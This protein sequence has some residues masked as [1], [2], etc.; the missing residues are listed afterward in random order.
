M[1]MTAFDTATY[2][3]LQEARF[4]K[5]FPDGEP[6]WA[7]L[8]QIPAWLESAKELG[9]IEGEV[10]EGAY[11][12]DSELIYIGKGTIVEPG[13]YIRGPAWIGENCV[14]RHGAYIRGNVIAAKGVVIGHDTEVKQ[15]IF[16][17]GAHAAHFAYIGDAILGAK[18]NLGAGV[19]L[20]NL[21]LDRSEVQVAG[22]GTGL[23]KFGAI[24]GDGCQIGCNSVLNPGVMMGMG[25]DVAPL[26]SVR[27]VIPADSIIT[28]PLSLVVSP[29][30]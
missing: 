18:V 12:E 17:E 2:F 30:K 24:I 8:K 29:K 5:L 14:V 3:T 23:K 9:W 26:V 20:A 28:S 11:L 27:G 6:V 16:L 1:L 21:R 13:A 15:A 22:K 25:C 7:A 4:K 10:A 19:K